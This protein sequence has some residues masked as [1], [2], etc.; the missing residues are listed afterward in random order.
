MKGW[1]N[2]FLANADENPWQVRYTGL[3]SSESYILTCHVFLGWSLL[4]LYYEKARIEPETCILSRCYTTE[5][6][7]F[8]KWGFPLKSLLELLALRKEFLFQRPWNKNWPSR[9]VP[10]FISQPNKTPWQ[11]AKNEITFGL[12]RETVE[13][14]SCYQ[15][16]CHYIPEL[17]QMTN[18]HWGSN[19]KLTACDS[20]PI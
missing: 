17:I 9:S 10:P 20:C 3:F 8:C 19:S 4:Q 5:L 16:T 2:I 11:K 15:T 6:W 18:R 13:G 12:C 7:P 14:A 1:I